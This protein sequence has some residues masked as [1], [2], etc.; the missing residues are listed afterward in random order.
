MRS[1]LLFLENPVI[2]V[3]EFASVGKHSS[4]LDT[5][6]RFG[7]IFGTVFVY[8]IAYLP[9]R[10]IQVAGARHFGVPFAM[11]IAIALTFGLNSG[12]MGLG[13]MMFIVFPVAL[14]LSIGNG[15]QGRRFLAASA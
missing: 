2:G 8:L 1:F 3:L 11:L 15:Q 13:V 14:H 5:F 6:A 9:W 4:I 7:I 10:A 12:F